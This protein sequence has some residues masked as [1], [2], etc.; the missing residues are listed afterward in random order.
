LGKFLRLPRSIITKPP[1]PALWKGQ[2]AEAE[3]GFSYETADG[4]LSG[5]ERGEKK[6]SLE[7]KYGKKNVRAVLKRMSA[8]RHKLLPAPICNV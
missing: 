6:K 3:L 8:N 7:Q 4:I 2:T 1:S 5:I